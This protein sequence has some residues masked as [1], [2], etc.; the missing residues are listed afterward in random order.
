ML[1]MVEQRTSRLNQLEKDLPEGLLVDG[2]WLERKGYASNLRTYYVRH[3]WL[4]Q[5]VRGVYRR[6]R[7]RLGWQQV[8]IS[9]QTI[10]EYSPL[11]VG[12]MTALDLQGYAHYLSETLREVHLYGPKPPPN[13]IRKLP[14]RQKF[15][16][17]NSRR[18]FRN[19]PITFGISSLA[20]NVETNTGRDLTRLQGGDVTAVAWGQWDWPLTISTPERALFELLDEIPSRQTFH[21]TD[22]I[23]ESLATLRPRRLQKLL[24]DCASIKVKRLFFFFADRHQHAWLKRFDKSSVD[25]G[26]G[27]RMLAQGGRLDPTYQITVP[28]DLDAG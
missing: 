12:G 11:I 17:H 3:G 2:A 23:V 15:I 20:W 27:K 16:Y 4:E 7:G 24:E 22:K 26:S 13:W 18:L 28:E 21:Q 9:L 19:D 25:L 6:K 10:L 1:I 8:V 5:P 14:L